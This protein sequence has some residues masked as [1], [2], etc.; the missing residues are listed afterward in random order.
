MILCIKFGQS[1]SSPCNSLQLAGSQTCP[2]NTVGL[3]H[4]N[5]LAGTGEYYLYSY[6][7]KELA[8]QLH[9]HDY[10]VAMYMY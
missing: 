4:I 5:I 2:A 7:I 6:W 3:Y 8:T 1:K 10:P 9:L